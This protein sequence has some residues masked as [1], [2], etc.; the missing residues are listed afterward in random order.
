MF[1]N[2]PLPGERNGKRFGMKLS[3]AVKDAEEAREWNY[4]R[5]LCNLFSPL[6]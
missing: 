2:D 6:R 1:V 4:L 5:E 3:V